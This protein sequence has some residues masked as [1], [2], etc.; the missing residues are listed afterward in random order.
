MI[1]RGV[2]ALH[3]TFVQSERENR[4]RGNVVRP[5]G[6][7]DGHAPGLLYPRDIIYRCAARRQPWG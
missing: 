4:D 2:T 6:N 3:W 1:G 5:K 7:V